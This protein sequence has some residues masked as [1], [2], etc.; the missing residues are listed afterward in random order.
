VDGSE[1]AEFTF[2]LDDQSVSFGIDESLYPLDAVYGAS[3][4]FLDRCYVFLSRPRE[5]VVD[6]RL[7]PRTA[8]DQAQ[9]EA[10]AGEF[11]NELLNQVIRLRVGESTAKIRE[12]YMA[13]A[14]YVDPNRANIDAILAELDREEAGEDPLDISVPWD[15][16]RKKDLNA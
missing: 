8:G 6:V 5:R 2:S 4:L 14:F 10:L 7:R 1:Q 12:Y 15:E 11:A 3:Y 16:K 13:R 9:L